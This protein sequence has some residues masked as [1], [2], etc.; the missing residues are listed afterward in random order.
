MGPPA[1]L[2]RLHHASPRPRVAHVQICRLASL[3]ISSRKL[4]V[5]SSWMRVVFALKWTGERRS[6]NSTEQAREPI[7]AASQGRKSPQLHFQPLSDGTRR[8]LAA[9]GNACRR[10]LRFHGGRQASP[11]PRVRL[12]RTRQCPSM[13]P[14]RS[15]SGQIDFWARARSDS[16]CAC[17]CTPLAFWAASAGSPVDPGV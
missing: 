11:L 8:T 16:G 10:S 2:S 12:R 4:P 17:L 6:F 1:Q 13:S 14:L 9:H 3:R 7:Q 5:W 15:R